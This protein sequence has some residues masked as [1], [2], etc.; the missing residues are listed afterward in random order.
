MSLAV[1]IPDFLNAVYCNVRMRKT[2]N[3]SEKPTLYCTISIVLSSGK[4][5]AHAARVYVILMYIMLYSLRGRGSKLCK[6]VKH[7]QVTDLS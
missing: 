4:C 7:D 2:T 1:S 5:A 6:E 3:E